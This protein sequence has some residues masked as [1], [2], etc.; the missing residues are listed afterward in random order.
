MGPIR[1]VSEVG[2]GSA[3]FCAS[4]RPHLPAPPRPPPPPSPAPGS[5]GWQ[6][7]GT[8]GGYLRRT[9]S[10]ATG[11][12]RLPAD[13]WRPRAELGSCRACR[14]PL[15]VRGLW[16]GVASFQLILGVYTAKPFCRRVSF[17][18]SRAGHRALSSFGARSSRR[19]PQAPRGA[20]RSGDNSRAGGIP[21][22][23]GA[24]SSLP[25]PPPS[26]SEPRD[27]VTAG[28]ALGP[29]QAR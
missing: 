18:P 15:E 2:S 4:L 16:G 10:G 21:P 24:A 8:A 26:A 27:A 20:C 14:F 23:F 7:L 11:Q 22:S 9:P 3:P 12:Q 29:S 5:E 13:G 17:E 28:G 25:W 1:V 6:L 19:E